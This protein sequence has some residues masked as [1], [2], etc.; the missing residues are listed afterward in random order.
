[1]QQYRVFIKDSLDLNGMP[2]AN[3]ICTGFT[4]RKDLLSVKT[5]DFQLFRTTGNIKE[6]DI[7]GLVD[8]YGTVLYNGVVTSIGTSIQCKEM[9]SLFSDKWKWHDPSVNTIEGKIKS[10]IESDFINSDDPLVKEKFPFTVTTTSQTEGTFEQHTEKKDDKE[11]ASQKYTQN[12]QDLFIELYETWGVIID[13]KVPFNGQPTISI[14]QPITESIKIGNNA[15]PIANMAPLTEIVE[16][17]RLKIYNKDGSQLRATYYG[18]RN[19]ITTNAND[20]LRLPVI[21][22]KYVFKDAEDDK[23][24]IPDIVKQSLQEEMLNHKIDFDLYL[25]NKLYDFFKWE[26][27]QPVELWYNSN[28]FETVFTGYELKKV[29][30]GNLETVSVTCGKVRNTLTEIFNRGISVW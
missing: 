24:N 6:G 23:D 21:K 25:D 17:N 29:S 20:P 7:L 8:P 4:I 13:I 9:L 28:Y 5:S 2:V 10:I 18:T 30:G 14:G 11:V 19:G 15:I 27:G 22:T 1:M 26:L 16:T 12:L 3:E